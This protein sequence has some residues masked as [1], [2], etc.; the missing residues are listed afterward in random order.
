[1]S[2]KLL[3]SS[4]TKEGIP[5]IIRY[6]I[7]KDVKRLLTYINT[8]SK[9]QVEITFQGEQLTLSEEQKFLA[10]R[11]KAIDEKK[12]VMLVVATDKKILGVSSIDLSERIEKHVGIFG[13]SVAKEIRGEGIGNMLM[14]LT[15]QETT[16]IPLLKIITLSVFAGNEV[17]LSLYKKFG[18]KE[19]GRLPKG[20][21]YKD[22]Y[23]DHLYMYKNLNEHK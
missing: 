21:F 7:P 10:S 6:P 23:V 16:T 11:L 14:K 20:I 17:A 5:F 12:A 1:M 19:Y 9:E 15:L 4:V 3:H 18:F 13:I 22:A 2:S 8:L